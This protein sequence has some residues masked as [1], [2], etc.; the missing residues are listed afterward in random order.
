M[1]IRIILKKG[2]FPARYILLDSFVE[3]RKIDKNCIDKRTFNHIKA[4]AANN[5]FEK[6]VRAIRRKSSIPEDGYNLFEKGAAERYGIEKRL[7]S[8]L[9]SQIDIKLLK[10]LQTEYL[11]PPIL[12]SSLAEIV[13][14]N[15]VFIPLYKIYIDRPYK[16]VPKLNKSAVNVAINEEITKKQLHDFI[17]EN[18]PEI[19]GALT[20]FKNTMK[21]YISDRDFK[22]IELREIQGLT[23]KKIADALTN[24]DAVQIPTEEAVKKAYHRATVQISSVRKVT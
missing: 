11:I 4:L 6:S 7:I 2:D 18:W 8:E 19:I 10:E 13:L 23:F 21:V 24:D 9:Q 17:D 22:I 20:M 3:A 12:S 16:L 1:N 15:S 5:D 14:M